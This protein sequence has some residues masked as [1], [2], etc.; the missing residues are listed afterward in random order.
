MY[1]AI[2]IITISIISIVIFVFGLV[3]QSCPTLC[4]PMDQSLPGSS[5]NLPGNNTEVG[6]HFL[7]QGIFPTQGLNPGALHCR[8]TIV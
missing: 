5:G 2:I 1:L 3:A 4:N 7:L 6:C 8:Q